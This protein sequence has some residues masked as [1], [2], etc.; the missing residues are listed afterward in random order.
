MK[1]TTVNFFIDATAFVGFCFLTTSG[2]LMYYILPPGSGRRQSIWGLDRH[3]WGSFHYWTALLLFAVLAAHLALHW[4]WILSVARGRKKES[5]GLR[6]ALGALGLI[7]VI[8]LAIAPLISPVE[9]GSSGGQGHAFGR[10]AER[11][12]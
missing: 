10:S 6:L 9:Q 3:D 12:R 8:A 7:A 11:P 2:I 4:R 1:R 5:S